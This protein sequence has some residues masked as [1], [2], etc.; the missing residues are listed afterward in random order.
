MGPLNTPK[1]P[2]VEVKKRGRRWRKPWGLISS[3]TFSVCTLSNLAAYFVSVTR[4][5][6]LFFPRPVSGWVVDRESWRRAGWPLYV[7]R[8]ALRHHPLDTDGCDNEEVKNCSLSRRSPKS[9]SFVFYQGATTL[10]YRQQSVWKQVICRSDLVNYLQFTTNYW[11]AIELLWNKRVFVA[12]H[13]SRWLFRAEEEFWFLW[14]LLSLGGQSEQQ[15]LLIYLVHWT[16][17]RVID[18]W[19]ESINSKW[20]TEQHGGRG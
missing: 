18:L 1:G 15:L 5:F 12:K 16:R 6:G 13:G 20:T 11:S 2:P 7:I 9:S 14:L 3:T 4:T 8:G 19:S 17:G 10:C